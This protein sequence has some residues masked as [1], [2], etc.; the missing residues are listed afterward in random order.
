MWMDEEKHEGAVSSA[1]AAC[2]LTAVLLLFAGSL[3]AQTASAAPEQPRADL[4]KQLSTSINDLTS[5]VSPSVVQVLVTGLRAL[6]QKDE[7]E[8]ALIGRQRTLGSGVIVDAD[9][10]IITNAHVV[11]GA[12]R[13]RVILTSPAHE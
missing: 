9:G 12:Q 1:T 13:V 2:I 8:T 4:L 11:K 3:P 6:E 5:R 10:Y 7:D